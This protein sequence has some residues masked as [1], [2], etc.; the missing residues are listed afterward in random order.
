LVKFYQN[1]SYYPEKTVDF[2]KNLPSFQ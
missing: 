1:I 2:D